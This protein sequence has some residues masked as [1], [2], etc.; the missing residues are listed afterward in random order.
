MRH[1]PSIDGDREM[2]SEVPPTVERDQPPTH[3][4]HETSASQVVLASCLVPSVAP[5]LGLTGAY[6]R[7][8]F[9]E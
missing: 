5:R 3:V 4:P 2:T 7:R 9:A 6:R 1:R 8:P